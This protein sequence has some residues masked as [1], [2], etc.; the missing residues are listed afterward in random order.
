MTN[1]KHNKTENSHILGLFELGLQPRNHGEK[2]RNHDLK[3]ILSCIHVT[4]TFTADFEL[5][6]KILKI[7]TPE[8]ITII[9][10]Q[11]EQLDFTLQYCV[12][13]MQTE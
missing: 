13:K 4:G 2:S 8:I 6:I 5:T 11:L 9:V 3:F 12:Q 7:G 1:R 10:V